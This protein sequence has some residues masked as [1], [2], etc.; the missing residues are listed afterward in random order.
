L[1]YGRCDVRSGDI[2]LTKDGASA[3]NVAINDLAEQFSLLSSVAVIRLDGIHNRP[4]FFLQYLLSP[5]CQQ[6]IQDLVAGNAITRLT[7][8]KIRTFI[9]PRPSSTEQH[10]VAEV[11]NTLDTLLSRE[12]G[13]LEKLRK[14]KRGL[15][16]DL[17]TGGVREGPKAVAV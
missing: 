11:L 16:T 14:I 9:V 1:I 15:T 12:T 5:K 7:L 10:R 4:E 6:R 2:L 8:E 13:D 17:L 3:G